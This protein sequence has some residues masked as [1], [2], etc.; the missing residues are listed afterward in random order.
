MP[1]EASN[2]GLL[3]QAGLPLRS[4]TPESWAAAVLR[5]PIA[6]LNDHAHLERKAAANATELMLRWPEP[7]PP[8]HWVNQMTAIT[9]EEVEHMQQVLRI[10]QRRGGHLTKHHRNPYA[11]GLRALVRQANVSAPASLMDRLMVC[12]LIEVR[13]CERFAVLAD[14]LKTTRGDDELLALYKSLW[15][16]EH[17]HY[18]TFLKLAELVPTIDPTDIRARWDEMLDAEAAILA[19]QKPYAG[20]HS[21]VAAGD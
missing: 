18:L 20:M 9:R 6:L 21:G 8:D 5:D 1:P 2:P 7:D 4:R 17:G 10:L 19:A 13:S 15:A 11:G 16:S 14:H 3:E 12:A